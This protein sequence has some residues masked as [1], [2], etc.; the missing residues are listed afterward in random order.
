MIKTF[1]LLK[2]IGIR[3]FEHAVIYNQKLSAMEKE[4]HR[5]TTCSSKLHYFVMISSIDHNFGDKLY[6]MIWYL[7]TLRHMNPYFVL[8]QTVLS[9][10]A[11]SKLGRKQ[12]L[13]IKYISHDMAVINVE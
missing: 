6:S 13:A 4:N 1:C 10:K 9:K 5:M 11:Q 8:N 12:K 3:V 7:F 2:S